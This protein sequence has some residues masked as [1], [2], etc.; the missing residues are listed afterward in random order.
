MRPNPLVKSVKTFDPIL[1]DSRSQRAIRRRILESFLT[2]LLSLPDVNMGWIHTDISNVFNVTSSLMADLNFR[3]K[4][5][6]VLYRVSQKG[7]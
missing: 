7:S 6:E 1:R 2:V 3:P 4:S 5:L